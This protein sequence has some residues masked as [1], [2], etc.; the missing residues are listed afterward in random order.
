M[1]TLRLTQAQASALEIALDG[2][3]DGDYGDP[4]IDLGMA[5]LASGFDQAA[6]TL[7]VPAHPMDAALVVATLTYLSNSEDAVAEGRTSIT[8]PASKRGARGA[9]QALANLSL[10]VAK[11]PS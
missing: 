2:Y 1:S 8:D 4:E 6:S 11:E 7:T 5:L 3:E 10:R 9:A